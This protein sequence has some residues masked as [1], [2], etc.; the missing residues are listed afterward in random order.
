MAVRCKVKRQTKCRETV[1]F[2]KHFPEMEQELRAFSI[3]L[4]HV[5]SLDLN[6]WL[7]GDADTS[8]ASLSGAASPETLYFKNII[9]NKKS[10]EEENQHP[11]AAAFQ[12]SGPRASSLLSPALLSLSLLFLEGGSRWWIKVVFVS[13]S[14]LGWGIWLFWRAQ[15]PNPGKINSRIMSDWG[16]SEPHVRCVSRLTCRDDVTDRFS[17]ISD[18]PLTSFLQQMLSSNAVG[19]FTLWRAS[20]WE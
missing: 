2:Q 8:S 12:L 19:L 10:G 3:F 5:L 15:N 13:L 18:H 11:R 4:Q 20:R 16:E 17:P 7:G 6:C 9:K 14:K 1:G